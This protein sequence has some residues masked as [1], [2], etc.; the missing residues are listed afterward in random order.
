MS[1]LNQTNDES[2]SVILPAY[3]EE[4]SIG[5]AIE[6]AVKALK[7]NVRTG[8]VIVINDGSTD[9]T[10]EEAEIRSHRYSNVR[11]IDHKKNEGLTNALLTGFKNA[12]G[13][14]IIFLC[15]DLQSD[16][17]EDIPKLLNEI[18]KGYDVVLGWRQGR[19]NRI[20]VSK[21]GHIL[22]K[23]FF[24]VSLHDMNWIKAFK[25]EVIK[26]L[27]LRSDWHRYIAI[28]ADAAG[29]KITEVKTN[30]YPRRHGKSKF[31][32]RRVISSLLDLLTIKFQISFMRRPMFFFGTLGLIFLGVGVLLGLGL[33]IVVIYT[34]FSIQPAKALYILLLLLF[35]V[36]LNFFSLGFLAEFMVTIN[37]RMK[38][39]DKNKD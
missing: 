14:I 8:E 37:E 27:P 9:G 24:G 17:E 25:R 20:I 31:G 10:K 30:Y 21:L 15:S 38:S 2:A 35:I 3:N 1:G 6:K 23:L 32:K 5:V 18:K 19:K 34:H 7:E 11:I 12:K 26:D 16:P 13:E 36:G 4:G 22:C 33:L 29:H 39:L 28:L